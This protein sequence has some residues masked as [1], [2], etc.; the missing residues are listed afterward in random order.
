M[1]IN[2]KILTKMQDSVDRTAKA[3]YNTK[4]KNKAELPFSPYCVIAEQMCSI[5]VCAVNI[6]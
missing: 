2:L 1:L 5:S 4:V 3:W 6:T